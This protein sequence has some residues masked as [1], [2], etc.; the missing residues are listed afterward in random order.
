MMI[1]KLQNWLSRAEPNLGELEATY[2]QH[3]LQSDTTQIRQIIPFYGLGLWLFAVVDFQLY[4]WSITFLLFVM[5]RVIITFGLWW[6]NRFLQTVQTPKDLDKWLLLLGLVVLGFAVIV[7]YTRSVGSYY[8]AS[9]SVLL[10]VVAYLMIPNRLLYRFMLTLTFS[11]GEVL[12]Y[13]M[14]R[15]GINAAEVRTNMVA[16]LLANLIGF[17]LSVRLYTFRRQQFKAQHDETLARAEIERL[18]QTDTL[19]GIA[20]RRRFLELADQELLRFKRKQHDFSLLYLDIDHFKRINDTYGHGTGDLV[21][22]KFAALVSTQIRGLD[23]FGRLGGE[24]FALL[25]PE[26]S[27]EA[28]KEVAERIR[29]ACQNMELN[30]NSKKLEITVSS[31]FTI[32]HSADSSMDEILHRADLGLYQAKQA[33]RNRSEMVVF[34]TQSTHQ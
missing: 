20:N 33:G 16:L 4:G 11:V 8:N 30:A 25:L 23:I 18:A 34:S 32:S 17:V 2:R 15:G 26:T 9:I 12:I 22:Q 21:L 10:V 27:L 14:L 13:F 19:T 24:E 7:N 1:Q 29:L 28:A 5:V 31:G 3:F 6:F